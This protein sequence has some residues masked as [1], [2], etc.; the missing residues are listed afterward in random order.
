M[1]NMYSWTIAKL[2][3]TGD[4]KLWMFIDLKRIKPWETYGKLIK[5]TNLLTKL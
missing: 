2:A 4:V 5:G 1:Q 3:N